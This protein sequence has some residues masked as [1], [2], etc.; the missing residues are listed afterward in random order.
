MYDL[1][2]LKK[3][4][5]SPNKFRVNGVISHVEGF[6]EAYGIP[7]DSEMRPEIVADVF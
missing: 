7:K 6:Y 2:K 1:L 4:V 3:D 5:H